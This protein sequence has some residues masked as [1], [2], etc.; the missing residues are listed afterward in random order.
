[1]SVSHIAGRFVKFEIGTSVSPYTME[2][3]VTDGTVTDT[4]EHEVFLPVGRTIMNVVTHGRTVIYTFQGVLLAS[5]LP[6]SEYD[7][8]T[9]IVTDPRLTPGTAL[10][11]LY[12]TLNREG[13]STDD[14]Y[15]D[16][17]FHYSANAQVISM[18]HVYSTSSHQIWNCSIQA[19]GSYLPPQSLGT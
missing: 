15:Y 3:E 19:D 4:A 6:W 9:L 13:T 8:G 11:N 17:A 18:E 14:S 5:K 12:V 7:A 2:F 1:M 10:T 16:E